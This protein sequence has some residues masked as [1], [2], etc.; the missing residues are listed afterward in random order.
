MPYGISRQIYYYTGDHTVE[1]QCG[2]GD[3]A[4]PDMLVSA[5]EGEGRKFDDPKEA[6]LAAIGVLR[7]WRKA[8]P[9]A[10]INLTVRG[11]LAGEWGCEGEPMT[12]HDVIAWA[13]AEFDRLDRCPRCEEIMPS[14]ERDWYSHEFADGEKFCS[15]NCASLSWDDF[16]ADAAADMEEEEEYA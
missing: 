7:A 9:E 13:R 5:Y 10:D 4:G 12:V 3:Y 8:N 2:G 11:R 15:D 16:M 6:T 1:I 14:D